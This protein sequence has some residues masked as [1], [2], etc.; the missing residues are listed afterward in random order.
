[1]CMQW[2]D[3][4]LQGQELNQQMDDL[5]H[6]MDNREMDV[7]RQMCDCQRNVNHQVEMIWQ[8]RFDRESQ[9]EQRYEELRHREEE[10]MA[11]DPMTQADGSAGHDLPIESSA[12]GMPH[13]HDDL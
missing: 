3:I 6:E 1:M 12:P 4:R 11:N 5:H 8:E 10:L 2:E 7:R 9:I 13:M